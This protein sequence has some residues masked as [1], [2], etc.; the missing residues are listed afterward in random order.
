MSDQASPPPR[1]R[2]LILC[3]DGTSSEYSGENTNVVKFFSL[4]KKGNIDEQLC[5]YQAGIGTYFAPGVVS[6]LLG[7]CAKILDEA[8]AWYLSAHVMEGYKFIMQ[9]YRPGDKI[10]VFGFSR[11]AYTARALAG[12]LFKVGLLPRDNDEQIP[13]AYKLYS[14]TDEEGIELA[15]G[16][17]ETYCSTVKIEFMGVWETVSSV[18][19][20]MTK[21]LP[22]TNSNTSIVTFRHAL[23]LDERRAKFKANLFHRPTTDSVE[24]G[25]VPNGKKRK[26]RLPLLGRRRNFPFVRGVPDDSDEDGPTTD[27]L[28]VWFAGCHSDVGGGAV[29]NDTPQSLSDITLRWMVRQVIESQCGILFKDDS[30]AKLSIPFVEVPTNKGGG[31]VLDNDDQSQEDKLDATMPLHD[32]LK[33]KGGNVLWWILEVIP[34]HYSW[35]DAKG[36]WHTTWEANLGRGRKI[37]DEHPKFHVTVRERMEDQN[38]KY[39][40]DAIW[41]Q[42]TEVFVE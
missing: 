16:F 25:S 22:F 38:L 31:V 7:W 41:K 1:S 40:P 32:Q 9:N 33:L 24:V 21:S 3:F 12:M 8:F 26:R 39:K 36:V 17:K 10:C 14:R 15:T 29:P 2:N 42:G 30:L 5:Y 19:V 6:P 23:A 20:I 35:Q 37:E 34:F 4:L 28:E 27:V 18:G 11:G 13:F